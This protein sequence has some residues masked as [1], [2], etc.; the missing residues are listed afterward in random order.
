MEH[1]DD[2]YLLVKGEVMKD[3]FHSFFFFFF[4]VCSLGDNNRYEVYLSH[5][6]IK[7]DFLFLIFNNIYFVQVFN[8]REFSQFFFSSSY[9]RLLRNEEEV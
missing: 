8:A 5:N 4:N 3:F 6:E 9:C 7:R 2:S 1:G